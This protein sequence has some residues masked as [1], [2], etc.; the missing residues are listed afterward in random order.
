MREVRRTTLHAP[1]VVMQR[2]RRRLM[3]GEPR[4]KAP[5]YPGCTTSIESNI[6]CAACTELLKQEAK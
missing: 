3:W 2:D 5:K 6:D 4:C 1:A